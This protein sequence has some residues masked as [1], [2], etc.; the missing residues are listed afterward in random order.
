MVPPRG[1]SLTGSAPI[2]RC[3]ASGTGGTIR[4]APVDVVRT[5]S[6]H[7]PA[8]DSWTEQTS[9][10]WTEAATAMGG[11]DHYIISRAS[12]GCS[13]FAPPTERAVHKGWTAKIRKRVRLRRSAHIREN[14]LRTLIAAASQKTSGR[15]AFTGRPVGTISPTA[16]RS[17]ARTGA[18][19]RHNRA[20]QH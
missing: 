4:V 15:F 19:R 5:P 9:E 20:Q 13:P 16:I 3:Q 2:S 8:P 7:E 10:A 18:R 17:A 12:H 14:Y 11:A 1:L 6:G